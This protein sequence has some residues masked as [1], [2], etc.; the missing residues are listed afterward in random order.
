MS[1]LEKWDRRICIIP[2]S[3][4]AKIESTKEQRP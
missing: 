2:F 1:V 3:K 4:R